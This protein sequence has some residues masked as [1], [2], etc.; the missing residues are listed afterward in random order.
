MPYKVKGKCIY[1]KDTGKKIGCTDGDVNKYLRAL[2]INIHNEIT[3]RTLKEEIDDL[4][5]DS[6]VQDLEQKIDNAANIIA[7]RQTES[8]IGTMVGVVLSTPFLLKLFAKILAP[9]EDFFRKNKNDESSIVLKINEFAEELEHKL[10]APLVKLAK[11]FT[12]EE[13]KQKKFADI[14]LAGILAILLADGGISSAKAIQNSQIP[15]SILYSV[16]SAI[17]GTELSAKLEGLIGY[18]KT[19]LSL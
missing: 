6:I 12:D 7:K 17:T 10:E 9:V 4:D 3:K 5:V 8:V 1:K 13:S 14:V 11:T 2:Q 18:I 19:A 16:K 15:H